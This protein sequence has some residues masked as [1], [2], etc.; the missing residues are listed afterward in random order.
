[1]TA[2]PLKTSVSLWSADLGNLAAEIRRVD[3]YADMYH[4]DVSDGT[5]AASLLLFFPDLMKAIRGVTQK[6]FEAHLIT[7]R[8]ERWVESFAA[9]GANQIVF[10]PDTTQD[11]AAMIDLVRGLKLNVGISL[12]LETPVAAIDQ[13][14]DKLDVVCILGTGF[15]VKSVQ[16]VAAV[17]YEKIGQLVTIR[18]DRQ[19]RFEIEA[20]GA[21][22]RHT[23]P[24][25]RQCGADMIV[26]GSLIFKGN[27]EET[28][29]WLRLLP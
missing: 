21:I 24:R 6:P 5:Y 22:R 16:D 19:L 25:L 4:F 29:R 3:P 9:A 20:D 7:Q 28:S 1:M 15:D 8:P 13:Y 17:A 27:P 18:R 11:I 23:V 26:P 10:Y 12:S 14:L 2:V